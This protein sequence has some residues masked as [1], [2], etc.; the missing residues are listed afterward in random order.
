MPRVP[1][2]TGPSVRLGALQTGRV[3]TQAPQFETGARQVQAETQKLQN[4]LV[5]IEKAEIKKAN[6]IVAFDSDAKL[7]ELENRLLFDREVGALNTRGKNSFGTPDTVGESWQKGIDEISKGLSNDTQ[8]AA[9]R[10]NVFQRKNSI[11]KQLNKHIS[12][13][14]QAYDKNLTSSY[15]KNEQESA[16]QNFHDKD[17]VALSLGR[18]RAAHVSR[19]ER[20]GLPATLVKQELAEST[21]STQA[22]IVS[23][24]IDGGADLEAQ[25]YFKE[26]KGDL[27]SDDRAK[28]EKLLK[29]G[30]L[31]GDANRIV[32]GIF[33]KTEDY[34]E[35]LEMARNTKDPKK[36]DEVVK[37]VK[38][39]ITNDKQA[40]SAEQDRNF[41]TGYEIVEKYHDIDKV[42][43][44]VLAEMSLTDKQNLEKRAQQLRAGVSTQTDLPL[45]YNLEQMASSPATRS[46]FLRRN[47]L[48]DRKNLSESDFKHFVKLQQTARKGDTTV[49]DGIE[50]KKSIVD[51]SLRSMALKFSGSSAKPEDVDQANRFRR[52]VDRMVVEKQ[53]VLGRKVTNEELRKITEILS[54]EVVTGSKWFGLKNAKKKVFQLGEDDSAELLYDDIPK[55]AVSRIKASLRS[56]NIPV[57]NENIEK[58]YSNRLN[59]V[60][61]GK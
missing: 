61:N 18:I 49:L 24:M 11:D 6:D 29:E 53:Q 15:I 33:N 43:Q 46:K 36:R 55:E 30:R 44:S 42:P 37:R 21:S 35:A 27:L 1:E 54:V 26:V 41:Q 34:Q 16:I 8:R 57:T 52:E 12:K 39:R 4:T 59:K 45:Y 51:S 40:K 7:S 20:L 56:K 9:F 3:S 22:G 17:R 31:V 13:E 28:I 14:A 58:V 48:K 38:A 2:A 50:T 60:V 23:R 19:G 47:L 32:D 25:A 10:K 5:E